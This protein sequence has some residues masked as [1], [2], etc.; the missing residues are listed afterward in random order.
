MR[1]KVIIITKIRDGYELDLCGTSNRNGDLGGGEQNQ[2]TGVPLFHDLLRIAL[3][4]AV[5]VPC[6][7]S[8]RLQSKPRLL[9]L[10][11]DSFF[12]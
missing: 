6:K 8:H 4:H 9:G 10:L 5:I 2:K 7:A 12:S 11:A 1:E 3:V